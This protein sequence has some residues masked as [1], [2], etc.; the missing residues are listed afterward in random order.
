MFLKIINLILGGCEMKV[1]EL[2]EELKRMNPEQTV[3]VSVN[4]WNDVPIDTVV[5]TKTEVVLE[6]SFRNYC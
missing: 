3:I 1:K 6:I 2:I 4:E 5:Q